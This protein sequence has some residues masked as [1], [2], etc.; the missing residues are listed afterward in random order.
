MY[1]IHS[2]PF[3]YKTIRLY[4]SFRWSFRTG[5]VQR[6]LERILQL[7][8]HLFFLK[9][10]NLKKKEYYK[11]NILFS[12]NYNPQLSLWSHPCFRIILFSFEW[13]ETHRFCRVARLMS[14]C[15]GCMISIIFVSLIT[16]IILK[17]KNSVI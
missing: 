7:T 12:E 1:N 13:I 2:S 3:K 4:H 5:V 16:H 11:N 10:V 15:D 17:R 6:I 14:I 8:P 9:I